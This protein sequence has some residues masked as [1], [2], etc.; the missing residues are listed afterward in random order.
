[1]WPVARTQ[2]SKGPPEGIEGIPFARKIKIFP[3][4]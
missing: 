3:K 2:R 4:T 1:M